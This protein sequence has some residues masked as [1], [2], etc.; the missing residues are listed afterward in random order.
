MIKSYLMKGCL[1]QDRFQFELRLSFFFCIFFLLLTWYLCVFVSR[2][3]IT[4]PCWTSYK[5]DRPNQTGTRF[6]NYRE[7]AMGS[8]VVLPRLGDGAAIIARYR[9]DPDTRHVL[10]V[11]FP[12]LAD[13]IEH[14][15]L[16]LV[17]TILLERFRSEMKTAI[18]YQQR[19]V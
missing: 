15:T 9:V 12:L 5:G 18:D 11:Q 3:G 8:L 4:K 13:A 7:A 16:D 17:N 14:G 6:H 2:G 1:H 19:I 10:R